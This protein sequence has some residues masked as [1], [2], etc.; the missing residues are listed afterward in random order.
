MSGL[1]D[2]ILKKNIPGKYSWWDEYNTEDDAEG[3]SGSSL[4]EVDD[5]DQLGRRDRPK[6]VVGGKKGVL[7]QYKLD[8]QE[9][10]QEACEDYMRK[11]EI[12]HRYSRGICLK[13]GEESISLGAMQERRRVERKTTNEE[14][15][16]SDDDDDS[17]LAKYREK[18]LE[19][20][21]QQQ[22]Q[23]Q[24]S[25]LIPVFQG[26][27]DVD[28]NGYAMAVDESDSGVAVVLLIYETYISSCH[29]IFRILEKLSHQNS[30]MKHVRI[31][32]LKASK[33]SQTLDSVALPSVLIHRSGK[34]IGNLTPITQ[35]L[36][37]NFT[38]NDVQKLLEGYI[39]GTSSSSSSVVVSYTT[40]RETTTKNLSDNNN[41]DHWSENG[42][43]LELDEFC[44]DFDGKL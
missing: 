6:S 26:V 15:I 27:E 7:A 41:N 3:K 30:S 17:F 22:Q 25:S 1:E 19:E 39:I 32:S 4:K 44:K 13:S 8:I 12:L 23:Q 31:L 28:P 29:K 42:S 2:R 21:K 36:P 35:D 20:L 33:F 38:D 5:D 11:Q 37:E 43:D 24:H 34:L 9:K 14:I 16:D 18:R 40:K 10:Q